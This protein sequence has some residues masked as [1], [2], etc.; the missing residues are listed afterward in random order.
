LSAKESQD[1]GAGSRSEFSTAKE[2]EKTRNFQT[3]EGTI[4]KGS[5]AF[6]LIGVHSRLKN[7]AAFRVHSRLNSSS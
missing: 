1:F 2:R 3:R 5:G 4:G 6:D 7:L